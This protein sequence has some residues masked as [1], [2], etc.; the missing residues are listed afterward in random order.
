MDVEI[1]EKLKGLSQEM[2]KGYTWHLVSS[3]VTT[4]YLL[5]MVIHILWQTIRSN[6]D[7]M[8]IKYSI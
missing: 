2:E 5:Q 3:E 8:Y 4:L 7:T 1:C 6:T